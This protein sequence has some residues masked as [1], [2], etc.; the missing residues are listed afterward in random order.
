MSRPP[1]EIALDRA[2]VPPATALIR[3]AHLLDPRT[4]I[5]GPAD[6]LVHEG[7][8]A[9]LGEPGALGGRPTTPSS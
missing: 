1:A 5:D 8:I 3:G 7:V 6:L 9:A 2:E 4:G